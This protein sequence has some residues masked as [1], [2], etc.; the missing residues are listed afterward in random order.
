MTDVA[1]DNSPIL[2]RACGD[3]GGKH[4]C[5]QEQMAQTTS[6]ELK[7]LLTMRAMAEC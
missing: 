6:C 7:N 3:A 4:R 5:R 2:S 1:D